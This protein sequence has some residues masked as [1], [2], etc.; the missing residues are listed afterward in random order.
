MC[1]GLAVLL[2]GSDDF[3]QVDLDAEWQEVNQVFS[4]VARVVEDARQKAL[5]PLEDRSGKE[6]K[7]LI[8]HSG[9]VCVRGS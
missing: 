6:K 9:C 8:N 1:C 2:E 4:D 7:N 5:R 3:F